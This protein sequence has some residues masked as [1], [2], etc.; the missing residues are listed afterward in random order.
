MRDE[1]GTRVVLAVWPDTCIAV[2]TEEKW[3]ELTEELLRQPK[4]NADAR[5]L[6]RRLGSSAHADR[7]DGQ[8]RISI[9]AELRGFAEIDKD[10]MVI[11]ALDHAELWSLERW[12]A[13]EEQE[14]PEEL[15]DLWAR[16]SF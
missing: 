14:S 8:G 11:G 7:F 4:G 13:R 3:A 2:W 6:A 5:A 1:L 16:M 10:V 15:T 9:P 12:Q